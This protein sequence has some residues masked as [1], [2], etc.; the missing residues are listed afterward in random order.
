M[1]FELDVINRTI[2]KLAEMSNNPMGSFE[3]DQLPEF[4]SRGMN[5]PEDVIGLA[6]LA[7]LPTA[8]IENFGGLI[9]STEENPLIRALSSVY[10]SGLNSNTQLARR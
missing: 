5:N 4:I 2:V 7:S 6:G 8:G 1:S 3:V 9:E 10:K